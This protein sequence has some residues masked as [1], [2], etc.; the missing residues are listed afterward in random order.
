MHQEQLETAV[1]AEI[2]ERRPVHVMTIAECLDEHPITIDLTCARLHDR[3]Y[4]RPAH[5]GC[6]KPT[7]KG[8]Q[9]LQK[10]PH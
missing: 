9:R 2:A 7:Q 4:I 1:L 6:F 8:C 5:R 3:G 10:T